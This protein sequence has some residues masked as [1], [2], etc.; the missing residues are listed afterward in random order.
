MLVNGV[1]GRQAPNAMRT[2]LISEYIYRLSV[3]DPTAGLRLLGE[4]VEVRS[5]NQRFN[6]TIGV[7]GWILLSN[8]TTT[9]AVRF[10]KSSKPSPIE[11]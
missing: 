6:R 2:A 9:V 7:D 8:D 4:S 3:V 1:G 10:E 11:G 5:V